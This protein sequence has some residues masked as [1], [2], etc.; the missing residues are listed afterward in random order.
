VTLLSGVTAARPGLLLLVDDSATVR[1]TVGA[2]LRRAGWEVHEAAGGR[3]GIEAA[4][5]LLPDVVL[6]DLR[7][8]DS[9]GFA[10]MAA[11]RQDPNVADVP[12]IMFTGRQDEAE[13]VAGLSAGAHDFVSKSA[14]TSELNARLCAALRTKRLAD[15]LKAAAGMDPLTGLLNRRGA[16]VHLRS[17]VARAHRAGGGLCVL[18]IDVDHF[19]VINDVHGHE[20]GDAALVALADALTAALRESDVLCRWAGDEFIVCCDGADE[21]TA[22]ML[23]E[24]IVT[25]ARGIAL[26]PQRSLELSVSVGAAVDLGAMYGAKASGRDGFVLTV[27]GAASDR[28]AGGDRSRFPRSTPPLHPEHAHRRP[29]SLAVADVLHVH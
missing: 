17:V 26:G 11:L 3:E 28:C 12:V 13:I 29:S 15:A 7:M 2:Q 20:V 8:P 27:L 10:V 22:R 14:T 19:K 5:R 18:M 16:G 6:L 24:R 21:A 25:R 4:R 1:L 23:C 9:D